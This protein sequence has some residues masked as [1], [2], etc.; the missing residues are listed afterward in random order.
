MFLFSTRT[1]IACLGI[2]HC[3]Q[4]FMP[5]PPLQVA[6]YEGR[7]RA[8]RHVLG[9][10]DVRGDDGPRMRPKRMPDGKRLRIRDVKGDAT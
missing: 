10:R 2:D 1:S 6:L 8:F 7:E 5:G 3:Q 9:V 4:G